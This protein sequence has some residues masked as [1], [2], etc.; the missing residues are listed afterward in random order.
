MQTTEGQRGSEVRQFSIFLPNKVGTLLDLV[1]RLNEA[2]VEVLALSVQDSIDMSVTRMVVSDPDRV[3]QVFEEDDIPY[4][5]CQV[6][7]VELREA[8]E[9][10]KLLTCVLM[11]EVNINFSYPVMMRPNGL[12]ALVLHVEDVECAT[13]VIEMHDFTI[14]RQEDLSR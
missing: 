6:L 4:G 8:A 9:L 14:L 7:V 13:N 11:A 12:A 3:I 5:L 2:D 1:K 10:A